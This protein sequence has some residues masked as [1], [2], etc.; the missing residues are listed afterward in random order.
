MLAQRLCTGEGSMSHTAEAEPTTND[1]FTAFVKE[2]EPPLQRALVARWGVDVG[3]QAT[4]DA[5]SWGWEHWQRVEEM[6]NPI[7]YLYRVGC[8]KARRSRKRAPL[9]LP[10]VA[11]EHSPWV[12]PQLPNALAALTQRQRT[13]VVLIHSF[14]WTH[15]EVAELLGLARGSIQ[16]HEAAALRKLERSLKA[17]HDE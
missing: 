17:G 3:R 6:G 1:R 14:G 10:P 15:Q 11:P 12:E 7:G 4:A 8:T 16:R 2:A 5:L 13:A 9:E